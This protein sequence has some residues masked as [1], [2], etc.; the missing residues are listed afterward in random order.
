MA[1]NNFSNILKFTR[2]SWKTPMTVRTLHEKSGLSHPYIS[3]LENGK[4]DNLPSPEIIL[5]LAIGFGNGND[6]LINALYIL[7]MSA[8][9]YI[10]VSFDAITET[11]N[12]IKLSDETLIK[13]KIL[14]GEFKTSQMAAFR[15]YLL[16]L[17][18]DDV[19][20]SSDE[21]LLDQKYQLHVLKKIENERSFFKETKAYIDGR[22]NVT[23]LKFIESK[24]ENSNVYL[25]NVPLTEPEKIVLKSAIYTIRQLRD[26]SN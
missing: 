12:Q 4:R 8:C 14:V 19:N 20:K 3:Q 15:Y 13:L 24:L 11:S 7:F 17:G 6:N 21:Q 5:K 18:F 1:Q 2:L 23:D 22:D 9:N 16:M 10:T 25:D 26:K